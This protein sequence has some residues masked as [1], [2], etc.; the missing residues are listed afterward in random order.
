MMGFYRKTAD[1]FAIRGNLRPFQL[2]TTIAGFLQLQTFFFNDEFC[3]N[4]DTF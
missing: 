2:H 3:I 1:Y 4:D